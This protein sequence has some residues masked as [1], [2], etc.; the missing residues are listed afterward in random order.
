[1]DGGHPP[2]AI[3]EGISSIERTSRLHLVSE[4]V[5]PKTSVSWNASEPI[6]VLAT[7]AVMATTGAESIMA[8]EIKVPS[9]G[10]SVSRVLVGRWLKK[11]GDFVA[12]DEKILE[13]ETDKASQEIL[14]PAEATA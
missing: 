12:A 10:E 8:V 14:A 2:S 3:A 5:S 9:A 6:T 7:F 1:M 11:E 4:R 13:V